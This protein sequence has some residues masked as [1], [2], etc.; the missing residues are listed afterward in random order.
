[1]RS[2]KAQSTPRVWISAAALGLA[3]AAALAL[4][5][6]LALSLLA[7]PETWLING[8]VFLR[9]LAGLAALTLSGY[10][11]YRVAGALS[12][13]YAM[14][15]NGVYIAWLGNRAIVPIQLITSVEIGL[16]DR[17]A[18]GSPL[19][20]IGYFHGQTPLAGGRI[21][22]RFSSLAPAKALI[23]N[24]DTDAYAIAPQDLDSFVQE[25][26][27]RRR[28]GPIQQL[29]AKIERGQTFFYAFWRDTLVQRAVLVTVLLNLILLGWL[30]FSYPNLPPIIEFRADAVGDTALTTPR[31]QILFLPLAALVVSLLNVGLGMVFYA[32]ERAGAQLLQLTSTGLQILFMV[33]ALTILR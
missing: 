12:L 6:P 17:A 29:S 21:L 8:E 27:Q 31:H 16:P 33:A 14:D 10:L 3:L 2:W 32:R 20:Q 26:E 4:L 15:R 23:I 24:T 19:S 5:I 25:L 13:S 18:A 7:P 22:H 30:M 1:M 28:L 9:G 11:A